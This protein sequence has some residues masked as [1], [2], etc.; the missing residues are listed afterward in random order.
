MAQIGLK[1]PMAD[2]SQSADG[3][4]SMMNGGSVALVKPVQAVLT[5]LQGHNAKPWSL[6]DPSNPAASMK[7]AAAAA[8]EQPTQPAQLVSQRSS[9]GPNGGNRVARSSSKKST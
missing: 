7:K 5:P 1:S 3:T 9:Q 8:S 4:D 6:A 2:R